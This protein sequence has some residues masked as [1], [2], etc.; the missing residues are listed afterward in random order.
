M[1]S[2]GFF[3]FQNRRKFVNVVR[4][5]IIIKKRTLLSRLL[6]MGVGAPLFPRVGVPPFWLPW[7]SGPPGTGIGE[8]AAAMFFLLLENSKFFFFFF[9]SS[10]K[11]IEQSGKRAFRNKGLLRS[12]WS[13][14]QELDELKTEEDQ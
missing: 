1:Q 11:A 5:S 4:S 14:R 7:P 10:S 3:I 6:P 2:C 9:S 13:S 12:L 8:E